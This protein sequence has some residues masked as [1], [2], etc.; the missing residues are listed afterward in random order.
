MGSVCY[1]KVPLAGTI[2]EVL[3][4]LATKHGLD[5]EI[6]NTQY[7]DWRLGRDDRYIA[8]DPYIG[9]G[10]VAIVIT[11]VKDRKFIQP[12]GMWRKVILTGNTAEELRTFFNNALPLAV[13]AL[14]WK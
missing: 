6:K 12:R 3:G 7:P 9:S 14:E 11:V 2:S 8:V 10:R 1:S 13:A 4:E 5:L